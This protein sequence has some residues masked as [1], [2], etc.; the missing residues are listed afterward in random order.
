MKLLD[1]L[2]SFVGVMTKHQANLSFNRLV[3]AL[4]KAMNELQGAANVIDERTKRIAE[5]EA[6]LAELKD[7][8]EDQQNMLLEATR[9]YDPPN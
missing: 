3:E 6:E 7:A 8:Y 2:L 9:G 1:S 5:L 4:L